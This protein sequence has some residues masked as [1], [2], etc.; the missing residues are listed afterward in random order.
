MTLVNLKV[1]YYHASEHEKRLFI[2]V[3]YHPTWDSPEIPCN[4]MRSDRPK[5]TIIST[6]ECHDLRK[7]VVTD[8]YFNSKE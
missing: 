7:M 1:P 3:I 8:L 6:N 2:I 4:L 5:W